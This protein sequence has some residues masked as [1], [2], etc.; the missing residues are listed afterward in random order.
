VSNLIDSCETVLDRSTGEVPRV[1]EESMAI[2]ED[3]PT[4][5]IETVKYL[6][7][8]ITHLY[9]IYLPTILYIVLIRIFLSLSS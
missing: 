6:F 2:I 5:I 7:D 9:Q 3:Q 1:I 4:S 8:H